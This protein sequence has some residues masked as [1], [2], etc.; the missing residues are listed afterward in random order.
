MATKVNKLIR[1]AYSFNHQWWSP[2]LDPIKVWLLLEPH[3]S[4]LNNSS[5]H[6]NTL[7]LV[8]LL[9]TRTL[10]FMNSSSLWTQWLVIRELQV[11]SVKVFLPWRINKLL[12]HFRSHNLPT[13]K[14][15]AWTSL[16]AFKGLNRLSTSLILSNHKTSTNQAA[17]SRLLFLPL[18]I[19]GSNK[20]PNSKL[21]VTSQAISNFI[22]IRQC[23]PPAK[24]SKRNSSKIKANTWSK[25]QTSSSSST[26]PSLA[27]P[28]LRR[29]GSPTRA[30][31]WL[32]KTKISQ[33]SASTIS[34]PL[35]SSLSQ[36][37]IHSDEG[38]EGEKGQVLFI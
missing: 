27:T 13:R 14:I 16:L 4:L 29:Q 32:S 24:I 7:V 26:H 28:H 6:L 36:V 35:V 30:K 3:L 20:M 33:R 11:V 12:I 38:H 37:E 5:L 18:L 21:R 31:T 8:S 25:W 9:N 15:T 2:S 23:L 34:L 17:Y 1:T 22:Q 10:V 19:K